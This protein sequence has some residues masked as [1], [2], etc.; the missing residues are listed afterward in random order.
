M[1]HN[2]KLKLNKEKILKAW[3]VIW[4]KES[5]PIY[6][7]T[8]KDI[9]V[10]AEISDAETKKQKYMEIDFPLFKNKKD[11]ERFRSKNKDWE[12]IACKIIL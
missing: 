6:G 11:A 5:V 2:S 4:T 8:G 3:A 12:I 7:L 9:I 10:I 1:I